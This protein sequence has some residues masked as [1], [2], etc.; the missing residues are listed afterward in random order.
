M[1][2]TPSKR[3]RGRTRT[4][5]SFQHNTTDTPEEWGYLKWGRDDTMDPISD[6]LTSYR[7]HLTPRAICIQHYVFICINFWHNVEAKDLPFVIYDWRSIYEARNYNEDLSPEGSISIPPHAIAPWGEMKW[8]ERWPQGLYLSK[9][10]THIW[11]WKTVFVFVYRWFKFT[12]LQ[13][14]AMGCG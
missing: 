1:L 6:I 13:Y 4:R 11:K 9:D 14:I 5:V 8:L 10:K 2:D 3:L 7:I 12:R